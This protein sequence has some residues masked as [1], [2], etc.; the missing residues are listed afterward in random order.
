MDDFR[1]PAPLVAY[2]R[3]C[4][5]KGFPK[6]RTTELDSSVEVTITWC[7]ASPV[8][9]QTTKKQKKKTSKPL[10]KPPRESP[11]KSGP[12]LQAS[13]EGRH[14][15]STESSSAKETTVLEVSPMETDQSTKTSPANLKQLKQPSPKKPPP[16]RERKSRQ[17]HLNHQLHPSLQSQPSHRLHQNLLHRRHRSR[18]HRR[19][20]K[21]SRGPPLPPTMI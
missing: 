2:L 10:Q 3:A 7:L 19:P 16:L 5:L 9:K 15:I 12:S 11:I 4:R 17:L 6:Y 18:H 1:L 13:E 8:Q 20:T 21:R 14:D